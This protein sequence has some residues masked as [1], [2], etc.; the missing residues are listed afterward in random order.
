MVNP[1]EKY[2][3]KM[4]EIRATGA[5][6]PETAYY[7]ALSMLFDEVG[8]S[9]QPKVKCF[10]GLRNQGAGFPDAGLFTVDQIQ[11]VTG[12]VQSGQIPA[13]GVIE[14]KSIDDDAW[15]T[16]DGPQVTRYWGRYNKV[17]VTNY[18]DFVL[19]CTGR[20]GTAR[21]LETFRIAADSGDFVRKCAAS[22]RSASE[23]GEA[24]VDYLRRVLVQNAPLSDPKD[25]AWFLAYYA[26]QALSHIEAVGSVSLKQMREQLE[27]ALGITFDD[28][29]GSRFFRS[30]LVQTL[31]YGIFSA[32]VLWSRKADRES[33]FRWREATWSMRVP[34]ITA[35]FEQIATRSNL[36]MFRLVELLDLT[37]D[38]LNRVDRAAFFSHFEESLA[39]QY[40]YEPFLRA[41][42]PTL[43]KELGVWYTPPEIV[44]Y[45][46]SRVDDVLRS[47]LGVADGLAD[48]SVYVLDPC[49]GTG[50]YL[51][52]VLRKVEQTFRDKGEESVAAAEMKRMATSRLFGFEIMPAPFVVA[53]LQLALMLQNLGVPL[54]RDERAGVY[55]TNSLTRWTDVGTKDGPLLIPEL[56]QERE[57]ADSVKQ[58][59]PILVV[60]GNPPYNAFAGTSSAKENGAVEIYKEHLEDEWNVKK[61]NLDDL[62]VRFFRL[63]ERRIS[64][65]T[66]RGVVCYVSNHSWVSDLSFVVM[67]KHLMNSFDHFWIDELHGDRKISERGPDGKTSQTVFAVSGFSP[68]IQ[69]GV[70]ISLWVKGGAKR[71]EPQVHYR[72]DVNASSAGE[73]RKDLLESL[74]DP[75]FQEHYANASPDSSNFYSLKPVDASRAYR[76]W[77]G[78][79]ELFGSKSLG[80]LE[81]RQGAL[82][83]TERAG[84]EQRMKRYLDS[85]IAFDTIAAEIP[86]LGTSASRFD[87]EA[88]RKRLIA[89]DPT[90]RGEIRRYF[91]R[92]LDYR[93]CFYSTV[94]PLWNEPRPA[95]YQESWT[96][97]YALVTRR[98]A[99]ADPEGVPFYFTPAIGS[100]HALRTDAW[101]IPLM[102]TDGTPSPETERQRVAV[103][104]LP[105]VAP[106]RV[107]NLTARARAYLKGLG[108]SS[109]DTPTN[110]E[111]IPLHVLAIGFTPAYL[112][113]NA[114]PLRL[115][116]PR[117]P[118]P[119]SLEA[120]TKS[121]RLGRQVAELLD[122]DHPLEGVTTGRILDEFRTMA[123]P[124][125]P[126]GRSINLDVGDLVLNAGWGV[127]RN[128]AV[129]AGRGRVIERAYEPSELVS[130]EKGLKARGI[131][132]DEGLRLLG[133]TT[134]DIY[135][136]ENA[137]WRNIPQRVWSFVLGGYQVIRVWLSYREFSVSG[138]SL[139]LD[140]VRTVTHMARR[141]ARIVLLEPALDEN[142]VACKTVSIGSDGLLSR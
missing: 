116:W 85:S 98:T 118:L 26:R 71:E 110:A 94:R 28:K 69:Q 34:M 70:A 126:D 130:M 60:I 16:A 18:R 108:V 78:I 52:E 58:H 48:P 96:G 6:V 61:Y 95:Y 66:G 47:H 11:Q 132:L 89:K 9:L 131:L 101:Y 25:V 127:Q 92:P 141:L 36:E 91:A 41:F 27:E 67:R 19:V 8:E 4:H 99:T 44:K 53:H 76:S 82:V 123:A 135:L 75:H 62:Y 139:T 119:S 2:L 38:V 13:R 22:R 122:M 5:V 81:K 23:I 136:N 117:I 35:L 124:V 3:K 40:F 45:M 74:K 129:S 133:N 68:G 46:V 15:V 55:L 105:G 64:E 10:V 86:G 79:P 93:W 100:E 24:F 121:V 114:A 42:D 80:L 109:F 115:D 134:C 57:K 102:V 49:C 59:L 37:G 72:D 107:A 33:E 32:W 104:D 7:P 17:L 88:T 138:R 30:S 106:S 137:C 128:N 90:E 97:N 43:R 125:R 111:L 87:P 140:E 21:K 142:Y 12:G 112:R 56:E 20:D 120:L 50:T 1:V 73:R 103:P 83:D 65:M 51:L 63:A 29:Q 84:L 54:T 14:V 77:L 39:V 113:E 31:F